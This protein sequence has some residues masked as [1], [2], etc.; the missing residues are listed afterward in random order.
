MRGWYVRLLPR[1]KHCQPR[2]SRGW[3]YLFRRVTIWSIT[4]STICYL[5]Y[6]TEWFHFL[7]CNDVF[8]LHFNVSF[9]I[10]S[11]HFYRCSVILLGS[12]WEGDSKNN[13]TRWAMCQSRMLPSSYPIKLQLTY[14]KYN[15]LNYYLLKPFYIKLGWNVHSIYF[16]RFDTSS[17]LINN[18]VK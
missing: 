11:I 17:F 7:V 14:M 18:G 10:Q 8:F 6:Y 2:W 15:N 12:K 3:Q 5:I 9:H 1:E 13:V 4:L 16:Y